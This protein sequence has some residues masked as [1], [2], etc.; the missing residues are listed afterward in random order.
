MLGMSE[1]TSDENRTSGPVA[2]ASAIVHAA[3]SRLPTQRATRPSTRRNRQDST[4]GRSRSA[5]SLPPSRT[6][7]AAS[8]SMP[9]GT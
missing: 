9:G 6:P 8:T 5:R 4:T 3:V 1:S 7:G 2:A